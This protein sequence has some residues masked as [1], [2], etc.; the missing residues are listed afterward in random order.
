MEAG[1][2]YIVTGDKDLQRLG[3]HGN[4]RIIKIAE[5]IDLIPEVAQ[6][7]SLQ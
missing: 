2:Q 1:S 6:G 7:D 3:Q 5:V 4:V